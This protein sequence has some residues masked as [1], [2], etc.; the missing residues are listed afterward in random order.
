[1]PTSELLI[2]VAGAL[3]GGFV[4]GLTGFGATLM[5][6]PIWLY[7]VP[8]VIAA[9][10]GAASGVAGQLQTLRAIWP[11]VRWQALAPYLLAGL[12]GVPIGTVLLPLIDVGVFKRVVG[13]I[14]VGFALFQL[15]AQ[16]RFPVAGGGRLAD[17]VVG[18]AGGILGGLA[19]ISGALPIMW[20][21][22]RRM[23]RDEKRALFQ[24]F[25]LTMLSA[26]LIASAVGGL[27]TW[28]LGK[29]LIVALPCSI[30]G[31][32]LGHWAYGRLE[33][34]RYNRIVLVLLLLSGCNLIIGSW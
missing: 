11:H 20:A 19:G 13:T 2:I 10:M 26:M 23:Q 8:H 1:V 16:D 24:I 21:S 25:N 28:Q 4:N 18:F 9:Q 30:V 3:L 22:V 5:A 29:A 15:I 33:T 12:V 17:A 34:N 31:A 6:L 32:R 27:L 14:L 7:A